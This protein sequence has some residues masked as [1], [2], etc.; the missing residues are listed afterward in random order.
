MVFKNNKDFDSMFNFNYIIFHFDKN[1]DC[2]RTVQ[3]INFIIYLNYFAFVK[4]LAAKIVKNHNMW[5]M[6]LLKKYYSVSGGFVCLLITVPG[7]A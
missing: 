1:Y 7:L 5:N 3:I 6:S 4:M 2:F